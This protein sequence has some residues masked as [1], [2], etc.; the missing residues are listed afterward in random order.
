MTPE[1]DK[2]W[3]EDL[4]IGMNN[5]YRT[6]SPAYWAWAGW[7]AGAATEREACAK[8][9]DAWDHDKRIAAAIRARGEK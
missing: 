3:N 9:A 1:F 5:P 7:K 8:V 4:K 6:G 2:W